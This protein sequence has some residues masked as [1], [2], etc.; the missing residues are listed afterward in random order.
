[1]NKTQWYE[2]YIYDSVKEGTRTVAQFDSVAQ[3][4]A[5]IKQIGNDKGNYHIDKWEDTENPRIIDTLE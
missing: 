5:Y 4:R 2:V 1:M 3:A